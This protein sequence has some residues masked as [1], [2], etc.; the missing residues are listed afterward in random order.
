MN[1]DDLINILIRVKNCDKVLSN[2]EQAKENALFKDPLCF[3]EKY[4]SH[5][6]SLICEA[7]KIIKEE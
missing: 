7:I 1:I 2:L 5:V 3:N 4:K 6:Y